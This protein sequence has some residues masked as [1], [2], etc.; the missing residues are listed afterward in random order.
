MFNPSAFAL[1]SLSF[2]SCQC[3]S[4]TKC[5]KERER[6][7]ALELK[8]ALLLPRRQKALSRQIPEPD[9]QIWLSFIYLWED[10]KVVEIAPDNPKWYTIFHE[11][12]ILDYKAVA[13]EGNGLQIGRLT[14]N[15]KNIR[16]YDY[17]D[18]CT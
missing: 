13:W 1:R 18:G 11:L 7:I 15:A 5:Q 12:I 17:L 9:L 16:S 4:S 6:E 8:Y 3:H 10:T 14:R 2:Q